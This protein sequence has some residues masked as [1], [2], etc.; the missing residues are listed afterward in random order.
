MET[1]DLTKFEREV[2]D[3]MSPVE[4]KSAP[5]ISKQI[6]DNRSLSGRRK[7]ALWLFSLADPKFAKQVVLDAGSGSLYVCF[8]KFESLEWIE[9]RWRPEPPER[10]AQRGGYRLGE[11]KL[12]ERGHRI[13]AML[14]RLA[15]DNADG[16]VVPAHG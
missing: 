5:E 2:L 14:P 16:L 9:F 12:T 13:R 15:E 11:R 4:W 6:G 10:T 3:A 1:I 8:A 7:F